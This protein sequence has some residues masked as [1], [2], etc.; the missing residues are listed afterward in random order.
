MASLASN[1]ESKAR[2]F[3]QQAEKVLKG[4]FVFNKSQKYE[5]AAELYSKAAAQFKI[6]KL[7]HDAGDAH[8]NAA[9]NS[10]KAGN[11]SEATRNYTDAAKAYKNDSPEDAMKMYQI[12][13]GKQMEGNKFSM[14]AKLYKEM[15]ELYEGDM[16]SAES[17]KCYEKAADC[18]FAE[19]S[20][21]SGNQMLLKV[22]D[23]SAKQEDYKN[24]IQI[25]ERVAHAS[26]DN[27]LTRW[28]VVDYLFKASLCHLALGAKSD[29]YTA[30][31]DAIKK[32]KEESPMLATSREVK[33]LDKLEPIIAKADIEKFEDVLYEFDQIVKLDP[34]KERML[35]EVKK[36]LAA[37]A[38]AAVSAVENFQ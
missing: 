15:A 32:Y 33:L 22:A 8:F 28:S 14:A 17:A 30:A 20:A 5:D 12:A 10:E 7:W 37:G 26:A 11:E 13:V 9:E 38:G 21:T 23:F 16:K 3:I 31:F 6:A 27:N 1:A 36:N 34:V 19:D 29:D 35:L 4:W 25:Y 24:A 18:F 2:D